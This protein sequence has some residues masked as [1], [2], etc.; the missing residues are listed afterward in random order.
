MA[1][2]V[3]ITDRPDEHLMFTN[4]LIG[5]PLKWLYGVA[6]TFPWYGLYQVA[7]L[8]V[9]A[10]GTAY[11]LLRVNP[12]PRQAVVV[13]LFMVLA[14][15]P[16]LA[17]IQFT[18]TAFLASLAGLLLF[19]APLRGAAPWSRAADGAAAALLVLGSLIR[20]ESFLMAGVL[21]LPVAAAAALADPRATARRAVPVA[22]VSAL[23]GGLFLFNLAY[24]ARDPE[25]RDF[26]AMYK[27]R[28]PFTDYDRFRWTEATRRGFDEIG[29]DLVDLDMLRNWYYADRGVYSVEKMRRVAATVPPAPRPADA[30]PVPALRGLFSDPWLLRLM[31]ALPC[32]AVLAGGPRRFALAGALFGLALAVT[33]VLNYY[34]WLPN[35]V[36]FP[37]FAG[38]VAA[39]ALGPGRP[40]VTRPGSVAYGPDRLLPGGAGVLTFALLAWSA[41]GLADASGEVG[42]RRAEAEDMIRALKPRPEQLYVVWR[43]WFPF[44]ALVSPLRDPASLR[45]MRCVSLSTV[46]DSPLLERRLKEFGITD[47]TLA[48][49]GRRDV[50][51]VALPAMVDNLFRPYVRRHYGF[52]PPLRLVF[53]R[54]GST[55][56]FVFRAEPG[57]GRP[58]AP[59]VPTAQGR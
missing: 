33:L 50:C 12:S 19:L 49:S 4:V 25:W 15:L 40:E 23:A 52:D 8:A 2:G 58:A 48:V 47:L 1:A 20:F 43:E 5:L 16:C 38:I 17:S 9:A 11:A 42:R 41:S 55:P 24:Y 28:V 34:F 45:P 13:L 54:P 59:G 22:A 35:R 21:L 56:V 39:A 32:V 7:A 37:L 18:K 27:A 14:V 26:Y 36:A 46:Q 51:L 29:W 31:L 30:G 10:A 3:A 6:P 53:T 57:P 44:E